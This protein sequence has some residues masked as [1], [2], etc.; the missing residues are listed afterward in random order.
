MRFLVSFD[1]PATGF[2]QDPALQSQKLEE[3][4][5]NIGPEDVVVGMASRR[6]HLFLEVESTR[7]LLD[8]SDRIVRDIGVLP[9]WEP[10]ATR[11]D[12]RDHFQRLTGGEPQM[13][14]H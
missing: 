3:L 1:I 11:V 5:S 6:V 4:F 7:D 9:R 8:A 12:L 13:E 2:F 14:V 10:V